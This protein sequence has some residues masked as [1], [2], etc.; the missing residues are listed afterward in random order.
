M[1]TQFLYAVRSSLVRTIS[2]DDPAA[3]PDDPKKWPLYLELWTR[4]LDQPVVLAAAQNARK[5]EASEADSETP[6]ASRISVN[7]ADY[8]HMRELVYDSLVQNMLTIVGGL[9]LRYDV[10]APSREGAAPSEG[11]VE[12]LLRVF[13]A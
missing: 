2:A 10:K 12:R 3:P 7:A 6:V 11:M 1:T 13:F 9:D 4:I 8:A 5:E